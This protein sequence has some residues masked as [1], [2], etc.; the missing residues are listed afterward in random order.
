MN[1]LGDRKMII[2]GTCVLFVGL[3]SLLLPTENKVFALV[4]FMM[5]GLG[6]API[7]PCIIHS[8]PSNFGAENSGAIID[9]MAQMLM[10]VQPLCLLC[11]DFSEMY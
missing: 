10:W 9:Q 5:I 3:L 4:G 7:Y 8:T 1:K 11:S 6:C 2:L